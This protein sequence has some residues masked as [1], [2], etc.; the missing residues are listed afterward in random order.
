MKLAC[1]EI[2][3]HLDHRLEL[4]KHMIPMR[5]HRLFDDFNSFLR[6]QKKIDV[7]DLLV[8]LILHADNEPAQ[9]MCALLAVL[10]SDALLELEQ[11]DVINAATFIRDAMRKESIRWYLRDYQSEQTRKKK[12]RK[13]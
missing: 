1:K 8:E 9:D 10:D 4:D 2:V 5:M 12:K 3:T 7:F 13:G 11:F 6:Q